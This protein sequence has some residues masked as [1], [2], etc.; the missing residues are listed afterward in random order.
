MKNSDM[1]MRQKLALYLIGFIFWTNLFLF[2]GLF[3]E[4]V[5]PNL[6]RKGVWLYLQLAVGMALIFAVAENLKGKTLL[7]FVGFNGLVAIMNV[8]AI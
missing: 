2:F 5:F 3:I 8:L 7:T 6:P 1:S 4:I